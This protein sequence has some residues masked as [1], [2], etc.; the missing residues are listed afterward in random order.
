MND[1]ATNGRTNGEA[2]GRD[3]L[4]RFLPGNVIGIKPGMSGNLKGRPKGRSLTTILRDILNDDGDE[5]ESRLRKFALMLVGE[6]LNRD[7]SPGVRTKC[8]DLVIDRIDPQPR[9]AGVT[10][11][12]VLNVHTETHATFIDRVQEQANGQ[13]VTPDMVLAALEAEDPYGVF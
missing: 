7:G 9:D 4:G 13:P 1:T 2:N 11:I 5:K 12:P 10:V 6:A 8:L 3:S